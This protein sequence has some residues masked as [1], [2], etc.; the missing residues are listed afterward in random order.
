[1]DEAEG[2]NDLL[3]KLHNQPSSGVDA[4]EGPSDEV[5]R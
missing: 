5:V 1:M 2:G 3:Y 4:K